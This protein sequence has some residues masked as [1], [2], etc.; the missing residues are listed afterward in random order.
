MAHSLETQACKAPNED[1]TSDAESTIDITDEINVIDMDTAARNE[2][3]LSHEKIQDNMARKSAVQALEDNN[4]LSGHSKSSDSV[5]EQIRH[6]SI[7][8]AHKM[9]QKHSKK[10]TVEQF[11]IGDIVALKILRALRTSTDNRRLFCEVF[12][13]PHQ[14]R[15]RLRCEWGTLD[16]LFPTKDLDRVEESIAAGISFESPVTSELTLHDTAARASTNT[17]VR[18]S[19]QCQSECKTRRCRCIKEQKKCSIHCHGDEHDCGNLSVPLER[20]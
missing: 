5:I 11:D 9:I 13:Q 8:N 4:G 1:G 20:I 6:R 16:R 15:Y 19:C 14:S 10:W 7:K 17:Q 3:V 2:N 18:I 12:D